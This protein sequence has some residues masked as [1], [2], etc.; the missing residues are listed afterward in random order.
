[1]MSF[2]VMPVPLLLIVL[3][4]KASLYLSIDTNKTSDAKIGT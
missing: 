4:K 2:L 1:M 3:H